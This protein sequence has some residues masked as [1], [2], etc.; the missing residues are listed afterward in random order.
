MLAVVTEELRNSVL[1]PVV[2]T[3]CYYSWQLC[4]DGF[5]QV[6]HGVFQVLAGVTEGLMNSLLI[7][8]VCTQSYH[9]RQLCM[10]GFPHLF[11]GISQAL[12]CMTEVM[13][14]SPSFHIVHFPLIC[15]WTLDLCALH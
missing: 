8:V 1:M 12:A 9:G 4:L 10:D 13:T 14:Y 7:C 11:F 2:Y 6:F 5:P 15:S 3:Q